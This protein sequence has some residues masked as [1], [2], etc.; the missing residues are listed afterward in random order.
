MPNS[1][2]SEWQEVQQVL[3]VWAKA[4]ENWQTISD[5]LKIIS[6]LFWLAE[7]QKWLFWSAQNQKLL[8]L[9]G[10]ISK[11]F[12]AFYIGQ[13]VYFMGESF[14]DYSWI[15]DFEADFLWKVRVKMLNLGDYN[16]FSELF[17]VCLLKDIWPFKLKMVN[18]YWAYCK[19]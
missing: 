4:L 9:I 1:L 6:C 19:F 11:W 5:W 3:C 13:T 10:G 17:S 7:N 8:V 18:I 14:Q 16:S 15:E 12:T 2:R